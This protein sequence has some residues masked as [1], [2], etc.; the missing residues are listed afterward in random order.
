MNLNSIV[1]TLALVIATTGCT[2]EVYNEYDIDITVE[3]QEDTAQDTGTDTEGPDVVTYHVPDTGN[4]VHETTTR[5]EFVSGE[6]FTIPSESNSI[7]LDCMVVTLQVPADASQ[8]VLIE[9]LWYGAIAS[10]FENTDWIHGLE[11]VGEGSNVMVLGDLQMFRDPDQGPGTELYYT[12]NLFNSGEARYWREL[13]LNPEWDEHALRMDTNY[14][15]P[16]GSE[17]GIGFCVGWDP[18]PL[19]DF[20]PYNVYGEPT[21]MDYLAPVLGDIHWTPAGDQLFTS[22]AIHGLTTPVDARAF[23]E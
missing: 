15:V 23:D 18:Y 21:E 19:W 4:Q 14:F 10:D 22:T 20:A 13:V 5:L 1:A 3:S 7:G 6:H 9:R 12:P 16:V 8:G 17:V 2:P 11:S